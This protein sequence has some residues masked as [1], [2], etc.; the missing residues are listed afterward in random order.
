MKAMKRRVGRP[1]K[2]SDNPR[3]GGSDR[4]MLGV[5]RWLLDA[6]WLGAELNGRGV[7]EELCERYKAEVAEV[8]KVQ[9]G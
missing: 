4:V 2:G 3:G 8:K 9:G 6:L 5:A 1:R 7:H